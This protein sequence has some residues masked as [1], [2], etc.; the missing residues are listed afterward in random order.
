MS[1]YILLSTEHVEFGGGVGGYGKEKVK[2]DV[3]AM[4]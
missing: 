1:S 4:E 2:D 3:W